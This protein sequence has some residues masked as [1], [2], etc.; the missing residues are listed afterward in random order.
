M[1]TACRLS[2][3][4]ETYLDGELSPEHTLDYEDHLSGCCCCQ[5]KLKFEQ[6]LRFSMRRTARIAT[7]PSQGFEARLRTAMAAER[8]QEPCASALTEASRSVARA[9]LQ[10]PTQVAP[11]PHRPLTWRTIAPLSVAAAAALVFAALRNESTDSMASEVRAGSASVG[12]KDTVQ[13]VQEFLDQLAA[14]T[15]HNHDVSAAS[16]PAPVE[17]GEPVIFASAPPPSVIHLTPDRRWRTPQELERLGAIW[18]GIRYRTLASHDR[19][20]SIQYRVGGH[21]VLLWAYDSQRV[22]LRVALE[23]RVALNHPVFVGSRHGLAIAAVERNGHGFAATTDLS[24]SEAAEL[25]VT[26]ATH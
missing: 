24:Q 4:T 16:A 21:R 10:H 23:P 17:E 25:V 1:T 9:A 18:E 5:G 2:R 20:P 12:A 15:E 6:A 26:A 8:A 19:V 11:L 3:W 7:H 13:T 14:D 22:P